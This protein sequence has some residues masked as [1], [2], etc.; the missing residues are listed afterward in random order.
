MMES[1][2]LA[3]H[4]PAATV[5]AEALRDL[6]LPAPAPDAVRIAGTEYLSSCL[7][8]TD[9]AVGALAGAGLALGD[10][11]GAAEGPVTVDRRLTAAWY[12]YSLAPI[13]W[14]VAPA[15]DAVAGDYA[16]AD[17]WIRL[18]TNAPHHRVAALQVLN[19]AETREAVAAAVAGWTGTALEGAIVAAGGCAAVMRSLENW[20]VHPQ[21]RAVHDEPLIALQR[22]GPHQ[23]RTWTADPARPLRG[24]RVLDLTRVLAGPVA[25]RFL[26]GLGADVLR[27]D[28]PE[29]EEP[30]VVPDVTLGKRCAR[31]D[32][33]LAEDRA[34][35]ETLLGQADVL[36][37][38]YRPG[39]LERLGLGEA[40]REAI[41]PGLVDVALCAWGW[42][43]PWA[44]RR[45]FDSLVQM[46]AGIAD[47][48]RRWAGGDQPVPLP[49]QA[50]DH[51]TGYLM[52]A[53]ALRGLAIRRREQVGS[54]ARL[55]LARTAWALV[56]SGTAQAGEAY[57]GP[58]PDDWSD[59]VEATP[60]GPARRLKPPIGGGGVALRWDLPSSAL[61]TIAAQW[62]QDA[63]LG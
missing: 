1:D 28:P 45:G 49:L 61:G 33:R 35:L 6:G 23:G 52:A 5:I 20:R 48:G 22:T 13:G 56:E 59:T 18:H 38:G 25:T 30:A 2:I 4:S 8:V 46:A 57:A 44:A 40:R 34:R 29:W 36:V 31:L 11:I 24:I 17:G 54:R 21:G 53:A 9:L 27:I 42:T 12:R 43:G 16:C 39:A 51:A 37:H 32:L 14:A 47:A 60:W 26:A 55:S 3:A 15:W 10:L 63:S 50:L 41:N 62:R 7:P 58:G 19:C